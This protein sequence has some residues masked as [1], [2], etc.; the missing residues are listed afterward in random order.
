[1]LFVYHHL[2]AIIWSMEHK[3]RNHEASSHSYFP[4]ID[5]HTSFSILKCFVLFCFKH[6]RRNS[7]ACHQWQ[8]TLHSASASTS[9]L[10][11]FLENSHLQNLYLV[12]TELMYDFKRLVHTNCLKKSVAF[13]LL[14]LWV[15]GQVLVWS[16]TTYAK[17]CNI[18][19]NI[20]LWDLYLSSLTHY[21]FTLAKEMIFFPQKSQIYLYII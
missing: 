5:C 7:E 6:L 16:I 13:W 9:N 20:L 2:Y 1:M 10:C 11:W 15:N 14:T 21:L 19:Q 12:H 8:Q 17:M 4:Y 18:H 3:M